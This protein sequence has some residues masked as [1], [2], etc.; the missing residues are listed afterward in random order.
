MTTTSSEAMLRVLHATLNME[1]DAEL[2]LGIELRHRAHA[3]P[4]L[5]G[6]EGPASALLA[7]YLPGEPEPVAGTGFSL[8]VGPAQGVSIGIRTELDALPIVEE[9]GAEFAASNGAMHACGHD[10]HQAAFVTFLRAASRVDLPVGI[11]GI[12]QPREET[13]PSG[14]KDVVDSDLFERHDVARM[15]GVH[16]HPGLPAGKVST[17]A[18]GINASADEFLVRIDGRG[19]HG[20][21]P[22]TAV[23]PVPVAARTTL[24]LYEI[25]R[26]TIDPVNTATLTIGQLVAGSAANVIPDTA[27]IRGTVRAMTPADREALH[28]G[29]G[30]VSTHQAASAGATAQVLVT[31]GEPV[32]FN[33]PALVADLDPWIIRSGIGIVEPLRSCGADDFS[34]FTERLPGVMAFLGVECQVAGQQPPLHSSTFLP[35]DETVDQVARLFAAM[36]VGAVAGLA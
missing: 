18:G 29:I 22:H 10:V 12:A 8:R 19:G 13:Y 2:E 3:E 31:R 9:T 7:R 6:E 30:R 15:L 35:V 27:E 25:L 17:G 26:S 24:A 32:L 5:S 21:Y 33:D 4:C 28:E 1:L 16:V 36:Y 14:A 34:F 23:D 20:A 11:L